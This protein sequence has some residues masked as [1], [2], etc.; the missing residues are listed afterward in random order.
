VKFNVAIRKTGTEG[1]AIFDVSVV[2]NGRLVTPLY[3]CQI[4][5]PSL[6]YFVEQV[7]KKG[8][9]P[10]KITRGDE[11][12]IR[13]VD[14]IFR[15]SEYSNYLSVPLKKMPEEF[16]A[17]YSHKFVQYAICW[18]RC[19]FSTN[20]ISIRTLWDVVSKA[21]THPDFYTETG[22]YNPVLFPVHQEWR[23]IENLI[24]KLW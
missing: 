3:Y 22:D 4:Y 24:R 10:A 19:N 16:A 11:R 2:K 8:G 7:I 17:V 15:P 9:D 12:T 23:K 20:K 1:E 5:K 13:Q 6:E 18:C 14:I 21:L